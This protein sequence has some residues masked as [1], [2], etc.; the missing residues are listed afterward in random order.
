MFLINTYG[1]NIQAIEKR[2]KLLSR[3]YMVF[4]TCDLSP[5]PFDVVEIGYNF[6]YSLFYRLFSKFY[7]FPEFAFGASDY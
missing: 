1:N 3:V 2:A 7:A 5:R 6:I 4:V